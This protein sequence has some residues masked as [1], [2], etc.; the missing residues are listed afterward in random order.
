[1]LHAIFNL[2]EE[3]KSAQDIATHFYTTRRSANQITADFV[4]KLHALYEQVIRA[5][6]SI[7]DPPNGEES[8]IQSIYF[9]CK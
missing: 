8:V 4:L 9:N 6:V 5:Q 1:M 7:G 2:R 3:N